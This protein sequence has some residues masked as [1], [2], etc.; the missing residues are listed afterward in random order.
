MLLH[1]V[2][3][4]PLTSALVRDS[5]HEGCAMY[6]KKRRKNPLRARS[7]ISTD[8]F[9]GKGGVRFRQHKSYLDEPLRRRSSD[10][11]PGEG[12]FHKLVMLL[13]LLLKGSVL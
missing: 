1:N 8:L 9:I 3:M 6:E 11:G 2:S 13:A 10:S 4:F 7:R 12:V 5:P